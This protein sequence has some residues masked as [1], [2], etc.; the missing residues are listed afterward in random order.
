M[1]KL[2]FQA[3]TGTNITGLTFIYIISFNSH[4]SMSL[5]L[6]LRQ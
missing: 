1:L 5:V 6:L 2:S 3:V 4:N